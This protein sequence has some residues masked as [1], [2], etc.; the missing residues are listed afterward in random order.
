MPILTTADCENF[1]LSKDGEKLAETARAWFA[2][3]PTT[4]MA[5]EHVPP[6]HMDEIHNDA[7]VEFFLEENR[8]RPTSDLEAEYLNRQ[9]QSAQQF[10]QD[11]QKIETLSEDNAQA[12]LNDYIEKRDKHELTPLELTALGVSHGR[13]VMLS[14][15]HQ[16]TIT[17]HGGY[18]ELKIMDKATTVL[19]RVILPT[20]HPRIG[21]RNSVASW[22]A[23]RYMAS[24]VDFDRMRSGFRAPRT[25]LKDQAQVLLQ[26]LSGGTRFGYLFELDQTQ[27][28]PGEIKYL[29]IRVVTIRDCGRSPISK[30]EVI[31]PGKPQICL[32]ETPLILHTVDED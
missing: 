11:I 23:H 8:G 30:H 7:P 19:G 10:L 13:K 27:N 29:H 21:F 1:L 25:F 2:S 16:A 15:I 22:Q 4:V 26:S 3:L 12:R 20:E 24:P 5:L 6:F 9:A 31:F 32:T 17:G 14:D 18:L 28:P